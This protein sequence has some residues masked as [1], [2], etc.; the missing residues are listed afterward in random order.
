MTTQSVDSFFPTGFPRAGPVWRADCI[1]GYSR[2]RQGANNSGGDAV[3]RAVEQELH[4]DV[5]C[6]ARC[7]GNGYGKSSRRSL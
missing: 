1:F 4:L 7:V 5:S 2:V 3:G 6:H